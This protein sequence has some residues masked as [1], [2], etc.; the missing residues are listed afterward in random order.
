ML[1]NTRHEYSVKVCPTD[2]PESLE[3]LLN[4]MS[5]EGWELYML[6]EAESK[7]GGIQ[8][9]CIFQMEVEDE[10]FSVESGE[11]VDVSDFKSR[12]EK[13]FTP[14]DEPY[15]NYLEIERQITFIQEDIN[16]I[17]KLLDSSESDVNHTMLNEQIS[18]RLKELNALKSQ[19]TAITDPILMYDRINQDKLTV[20]IS[21]ELLDL[22]GNEKGGLLIAE[23]IKLRQKLTDKLGYVIPSIRFTDSDTLEANEYRIE[24]RGIKAISGNVYPE[25][26]RFFIGQSNIT[27]KP[28]DAI[29]DVDPV[30]GERVFWIAEN[31]TKDFWEKG[32]TPAEAIA[33]SIEYIARKYVDQLF[34]YNDMNQYIAIA[35]AQNLFLIENLIP[36][37]LTIAD[38]RY[39]FT[40]L[41]REKVSVK[42]TVYIF[43]KLND[44]IQYT[45]DKAE[46]LEK[47]RIALSRQICNSIADE[48]SNI[49]GISITEN[50]A[51][52]L[53][54]TFISKDD[55]FLLD[56][57]SPKVNKIV[58]EVVRIVKESEFDLSNMAI[59]SPAS[60]RQQLFNL[61][62]KIVPGLTVISNQELVS[63]FN[64]ETIGIIG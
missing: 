8:Y 9:N 21:Y 27:K 43:E 24:V 22:V 25:Y 32:L 4:E 18:S 37:L 42:D 2:E 39:L 59:I 10:L 55:A 35:G 56:S 28:K 64:L 49:Y 7:S 53:E 15:Q 40:N 34:D 41:I 14:S 29:E 31:K 36:E 6:H 47:L 60:I 57:K 52:S 58:K 1:D 45:V 12:M 13:V 50:L 38:L 20:V 3:I 23:T 46:L 30:T 11:I 19:I 5:E 62:E 61:F 51:D 44:F 16:K 26:Q 17:K 54:N 33:S 48:N 63:E